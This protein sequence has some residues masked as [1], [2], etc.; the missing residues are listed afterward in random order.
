MRL[1]TLTGMIACTPIA[2]AQTFTECI[3]LRDLSS[4]LVSD[5]RRAESKQADTQCPKEKFK[6]KLN[7]VSDWAFVT[8]VKARQKCR[9]QWRAETAYKYKDIFGN[10]YRTEEGIAIAQSL[11]EVGNQMKSISCPTS[12]LKW[13]KDEK[14][15][16]N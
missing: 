1:L 2:S 13:T 15:K 3:A 8:D 12:D 10:E 4:V 7:N 9:A 5:A 6:R 11:E 14:L 16:E